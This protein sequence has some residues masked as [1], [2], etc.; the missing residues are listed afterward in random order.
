MKDRIITIAFLI[1]IFVFPIGTIFK[2]CLGDSSGA[3]NEKERLA[4]EANGTIIDG[5]TVR[6]AAPKEQE[7]HGFQKVLGVMSNFTKDM[8]F[9]D[10]MVTANAE[11][12]YAFSFGEYVEST[13]V[14]LGKDDYLFFKAKGDGDSIADY[15]GT[16]LFTNEQLLAITGNLVN[17]RDAMYARGI[18][19]Y[20]LAIPNKEIV[21]A[22]YMPDIIYRDSDFT[23]GQ[24]LYEFVTGNTDIKMLY[25]LEALRAAKEDYQVYY[26]GDTH[27]NQ[28]GAFIVFGELYYDMYGCRQPIEEAKFNVAATNHTG[29]LGILVNLKDK[30]G[31]DTVYAFEQ[32]DNSYYR[33]ETIMFIGDSFSGFL[34]NVAERYYR[35]VYRVDTASFTMEMLDEYNPDIVVFETAERKLEVLG[36]SMND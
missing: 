7:V 5:K 27:E 14:L 6:A 3:A 24:Q 25:P 26:K 19:F 11:L 1:I 28:I 23:R 18:E 22:E 4:L 20:A 31:L 32:T 2:N 12:T 30:Q 17:I 9:K 35:E 15:K 16:N 33:D 36:S 21:Y 8:I 10:Y 34:S 13:Q 29:D